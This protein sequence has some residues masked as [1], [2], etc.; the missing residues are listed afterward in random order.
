MKEFYVY[1]YLNP[2]VKKSYTISKFTSEYEPFYVGKGK[3]NR[4]YDH[5][6]PNMLKISN[7][8]YN[9][10]SSIIDDIGIDAYKKN[11]I[12]KIDDKLSNNT[13]LSLEGLIMKEIGTYYDIHP[14]IKPGPLLN[15]TLAGVENPILYGANNAMYNKS[16]VDIWK[17]KHNIET[18][19]KLE[20]DYSL[21]QSNSGTIRWQDIK[22]DDLKYEEICK[23]INAG[24]HRY[25]DS[26]SVE[27]R[28]LVSNTRSAN[29]KTFYKKY[30]TIENYYIE[31][32]G[33]VEGVRL[34]EERRKNISKGLISFWDTVDDEFK[35]VHS[36]KTSL[37]LRKFLKKHGSVNEYLLDKLGPEKFKERQDSMK[38]NQ[39]VSGKRRWAHMSIAERESLK[40][41]KR[42]TYKKFIESMSTIEYQQYKAKHSG[43]NNPM[44]NMGKLVSGSKNGRATQWIAHLPNGDRYY[45]DGTFKAFCRTVLRKYKPHPHRKYMDEILKY[46]TPVF[47][48]YF[49]RVDRDFDYLAENT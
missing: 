19:K 6:R 43:E 16:I 32:Y 26:L 23:N 17:S 15:F 25:W 5:L 30:G 48:W 7:H 18:V 9:L 10:L 31:T 46:D 35:R 8:R 12:V 13:A 44:Y 39:S 2:R 28:I 24:V 36:L 45:C 22:A 33:L 1:V 29:F 21:K 37:G 49:K 3:N 34:E 38:H 14:D 27:D 41:K 20:E 40:Q 4:L 11:F 42:D 47:G